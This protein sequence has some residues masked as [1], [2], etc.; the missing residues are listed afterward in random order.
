M[1]AYIILA[2]LFLLSLGGI[3]HGTD[4]APILSTQLSS[5]KSESTS[6]LKQAVAS[7]KLY[8][9]MAAM[10]DGAP[11]GQE[12]TCHLHIDDIL[13]TQGA[14]RLKSLIIRPDVSQDPCNIKL[15]NIAGISR[16]V[17]LEYFEID[18][19]DD[20]ASA[21]AIVTAVSQLPHLKKLII[22]RSALE[23][24]PQALLE[25]K[26]LEDLTIYAKEISLPP[27]IIQ[28]TKLRSLTLGGGFPVF[29]D[30]IVNMSGL[31][32]VYCDEDVEFNHPSEVSNLKK[33]LPSLNITYQNCYL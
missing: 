19:V 10:G 7:G 21:Q 33:N 9:R 32:V 18:A 28:L 8:I 29:P 20:A 27:D 13:K 11:R 17:S 14:E 22:D 4:D 16:L 12:N 31:T 23:K 26:N 30:T 1:K 3:A 25:L 5:G 15:S 24:F 6:S 2:G